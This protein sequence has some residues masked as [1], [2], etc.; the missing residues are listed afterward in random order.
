MAKS[1]RKLFTVHGSIQYTAD[2]K[3]LY[4][5]KD[6]V[7]LRLDMF[8]RHYYKLRP[9]GNG[10]I[11]EI[12]G[13]RMHLVK[14]FKSPLDYSKQVVR[15]LKIPTTGSFSALDTCMGLGYTA[16]ALAKQ[17]SINLVITA[18]L[19]EAVVALAKWNPFSDPLFQKESKIM[20]MPGSI[21]DLIKNFESETFSFAIHDPPRIS[22]ASELYSPEFYSQL[23]R[24]CKTGARIFHYVGSVG[25]SKGRKIEKE[26][27]S[28][29]ESAGFSNLRYSLRLQ[30]IFG[31]KP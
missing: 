2:D 17:Q 18:E 19:S 10:I 15:E 21:F 29:L 1:E 5:E 14:D 7:E 26:V 22:H 3:F 11:L 8:D 13:L 27:A 9:Y 28:R 6:G 16:I 20:L 12:D 24:V 25:V 31:T 23:Y 30:G 4:A